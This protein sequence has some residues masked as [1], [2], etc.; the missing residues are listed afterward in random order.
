MGCQGI[1]RLHP[2]KSK[3]Q[4]MTA[5]HSSTIC[6]QGMMLKQTPRSSRS[7]QRCCLQQPHHSCQR[8]HSCHLLLSHI[9]NTPKGAYSSRGRS[10]HLLA[11]PFSEPLLRTL[12]RTLFHCKPHSSP[13]LRTLLRTPSPEP[14][15]E[16]CVAVRP[17]RRAPNHRKHSGEEKSVGAGVLHKLAADPF[18]WL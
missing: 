3:R 17:L 6:L 16:R 15:L 1:A 11:T 4:T 8:S 12:L 14:F 2:S 18:L 10:R 7:N 9:G 5:N 13:L